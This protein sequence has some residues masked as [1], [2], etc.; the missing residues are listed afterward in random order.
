M[1]T[2]VTVQAQRLPGLAW[3]YSLPAD[4]GRKLLI[5]VE[6]RGPRHLALVDSSRDDSLVTVR[7]SDEDASGV[8]ALLTGARFVVEY[9]E[10]AGL[11]GREP[12]TDE[13]QHFADGRPPQLAR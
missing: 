1:M 2:D 3:R 6:D 5:V 13:R 7:L 11:H 12:D 4:Q 10:N 8:A 9:P